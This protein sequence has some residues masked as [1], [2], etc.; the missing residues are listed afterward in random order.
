MGSMEHLCRGAQFGGGTGPFPASRRYTSYSGKLL[1][2]TLRDN[3]AQDGAAATVPAQGLA[4]YPYFLALVH[5]S[6]MT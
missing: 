5:S 3:G 2:H 4:F 6:V 1:V